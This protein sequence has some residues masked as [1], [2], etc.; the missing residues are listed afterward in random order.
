MTAF[1]FLQKFESG[2]PVAMPYQDVVEALSKYGKTGRGRGDLEVTLPPDSIAAL[3]TIVGS[4]EQ[5]ASCIA[6]ERPRYDDDLRNIVWEMMVRFRCTV[7]DDTLDTLCTPPHGFTAL[8]EGMSKAAHFDA[9]EICALQ[10]L[11]PKGLEYHVEA[12]DIPALRYTNPNPNGPNLQMFDA[13]SEPA[14]LSNFTIGLDIR[15]EACNDGTLRALRNLQLRVDSA[16]NANEGFSVTYDFPDDETALRLMRSEPL[17]KTTTRA[18]ILTP[19]NRLGLNDEPRRTPFIADR[20]VFNSSLQQSIRLTKTAH[21]THQMAMDGSIESIDRLGQFL[22]QMHAKEKDF[23]RTHYPGLQVNVSTTT[24]WA[25]MAGCYLGTVIRQ[26]V[27]GQWGYIRRGHFR[28]PVVRTH[29]K[30][31]INPF[32]LV[33]DHIINGPRSS[34]S[35][36]FSKL[37]AE[38]KSATP[39]NDDIV[40]DIAGFGGI[41]RGES[42]WSTGGLPLADTIPRERLDYSVHSLK[43][44]D[45]YLARVA[46][47]LGSFT[48]MD[49]SNLM[50]SAGAYLG[51]VV[52]SNA[53]SKGFWNW[54][55]YDDYAA[56]QP[57]FAQKRPR[58]A[59]FMAILD[60]PQQAAYPVGQ[61]AD[62]I[63]DPNR[64]PPPAKAHA[65]AR[66][67]VNMG[68]TSLSNSELDALDIRARIAALNEQERKVLLIRS[69]ADWIRRDP[70]AQLFENMETLLTQGWLVWGHVVQANTALFSP[71]LLNAP[72]EII[73]DPQGILTPEEL[74]PIAHELFAL[75]QKEKQLDPGKPEDAELLPIARHLNAET[76]RAFGMKVPARYSREPLLLSTVMFERRHF[77]ESKLTLPY[78]PIL[79][80]PEIP[81]FAMV[82]HGRFWPKPLIDRLKNATNSEAVDTWMAQWQNATPA[83]NK[84]GQTAPTQPAPMEAHPAVPAYEE[85]SRAEIQ[86]TE[87]ALDNAGTAI[88]WAL[89]LAIWLVLYFGAG[90]MLDLFHK[91]APLAQAGTHG[92]YTFWVIF[93]F[94]ALG[95]ISLVLR[96]KFIRDLAMLFSAVVIC[97]AGY[98]IYSMAHPLPEAGTPP[99]FIW[100]PI[101]QLV[102]EVI[103]LYEINRRLVALEEP[104]A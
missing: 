54:E 28:I 78:F 39:R 35:A 80:C 25:Q 26:Q 13:I 37:L 60:S 84:P 12:I 65:Y 77:P 57:D 11:W 75:R 40:K 14:A 16:L 89:R 103:V 70:I 22:D 47:Q 45:E 8:P 32:L 7:F 44:L 18:I 6:F 88:G 104:L 97:L 43:Y 74:K 30:R 42:N 68:R 23:R 38:G 59:M 63:H 58:H 81:G 55:P 61:I 15:L 53:V 9:R 49:I 5:G 85:R 34:I 52:R 76:T 92:G 95:V 48:K 33:M 69:D 100:G 46:A 1:L 67:L 10:Q 56:T 99:V 79:I 93:P 72:G 71:G 36:Y 20:E 90:S 50:L 73:Y 3:C 82:L 51:E 87:A 2:Q 98:G 64:N 86:R 66:H 27:G 29:R 17:D 101:V 31:I 102:W 96:R 91:Y 19:G 41:L 62:L 21:D 94:A 83:Q 24:E 4:S